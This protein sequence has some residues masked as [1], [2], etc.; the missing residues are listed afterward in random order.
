MD[1]TAIVV[2]LVVAIVCAGI[3]T[4][5]IPR[6]MPGGWFGYIVVGL[7]GVWLGDWAYSALDNQ[8]GLNFPVLDWGLAGVRILPSVVG[9]AVILFVATAFLKWGRYGR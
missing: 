6:Q 7:A 4:L 5:L 2:K 3:G 1:I 9:S 8:Y